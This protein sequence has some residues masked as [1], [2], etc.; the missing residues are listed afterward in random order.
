MMKS[1]AVTGDTRIELSESHSPDNR[2]YD[3][4]FGGPEESGRLE[5]NYSERSTHG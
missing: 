5:N 1:D 3:K 2:Y 4:E